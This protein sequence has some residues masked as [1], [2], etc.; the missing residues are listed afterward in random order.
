MGP[1]ELDPPDDRRRINAAPITKSVHRP[2]GESPRRDTLECVAVPHDTGL[3]QDSCI[4]RHQG[5]QFL[6]YFEESLSNF[7]RQ[8]RQNLHSNYTIKN[9]FGCQ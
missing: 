4:V 1:P 8:L 6:M 5:F 2:I 3:G 9:R 7:V